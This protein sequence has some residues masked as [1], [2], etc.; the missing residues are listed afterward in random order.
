MKKLLTTTLLALASVALIATS[1]EAA[2]TAVFPDVVLGFAASGGSGAATNLEVD[3]GNVSQFYNAAPGSVTTITQLSPLDLAQIYG[4]TWFSRS[5]L[6]FGAFATDITTATPDGHSPALTNWLTDPETTPG[7][8]ATPLNRVIGAFNQQAETL[9]GSTL[10]FLNGAASTANSTQST[11]YPN[12]SGNGSY[13]GEEL[14]GGPGTFWRTY[15]LT[16]D[17]AVN[18]IGTGLAAISDFYEL[19]PGSGPAKFLGKF[20]LFQTGTLEFVAAPVPEPSSIGLMGVG[21]LSLVGMVVLRR[22][23][24]VVG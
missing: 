24:S 16:P 17:N 23:R 11:A 5:D 10:S 13:T 12:A 18:N 1:A 14:F 21:F 2:V 22:R 8:L 15:H 6:T 3:L 19:D 4:A 20:E 7:T 9:M